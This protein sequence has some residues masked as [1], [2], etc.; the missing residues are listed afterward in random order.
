MPVRVHGQRQ[1]AIGQEQVELPRIALVAGI[2]QRRFRT[3]Q[4]VIA[5]GGNGE[6]QEENRKK[7]AGIN[8]HPHP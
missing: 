3:E 7:E 1:H 8:A 2:G 6:Y 4:G 5:N